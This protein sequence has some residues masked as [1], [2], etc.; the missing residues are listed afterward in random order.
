MILLTSISTEASEHEK[1]KPTVPFKKCLKKLSFGQLKYER[2]G[3]I[4]LNYLILSLLSRSPTSRTTT[5][6][7]CTSNQCCST[8]TRYNHFTGDCAVID[9]STH[10]MERYYTNKRC[11]QVSS[12]RC[13]GK[14]ST[15]LN[16][17]FYA[18]VGSTHPCSP[19]NKSAYRIRFR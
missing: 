11:S 16:P 17:Y 5:H 14:D 8:G 18:G 9:I 12:N 19:T 2:E 7:H 3:H 1:N 6:R 13:N 15:P 10:P 4:A